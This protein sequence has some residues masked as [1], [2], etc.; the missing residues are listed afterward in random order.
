MEK[1]ILL[2]GAGGHSKA[3]IEII[4]HGKLFGIAGLIDRPDSPISDVLGYP[5]LGDDSSLASLSSKITYA[6]PAIGFLNNQR[7]RDLLFEKLL[8]CGFQVPNIVSRRAYVSKHASMGS[9]NVVMHDATISVENVI[10]DNN[11]IQTK[12]LMDHDVVIG[13]HNYISTGSVLN[14]AVKLGNYNLIGSNV[15][16][17]QG[18]KIGDNV[19]VGSGAVVVNDITDAGTYAGIPAK[20]I[21]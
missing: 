21:K 18:C 6:F 20:R 19:K 3:I 14:G 2:V 9:G 11:I 17:N 13:H 10:G 15:T 5:I 16:I 7:M 1:S 12:S 8:V 4:E